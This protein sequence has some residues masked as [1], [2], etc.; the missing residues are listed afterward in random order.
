MFIIVFAY[1]FRVR[2]RRQQ[3]WWSAEYH[4][5]AVLQWVWNRCDE[6]IAYGW[7]RTSLGASTCLGWQQT[8]VKTIENVS[9]STWV[10]NLLGPYF[11]NMQHDYL[12]GS[13]I[14]IWII[15]GIAGINFTRSV[16][17]LMFTLD[18]I[19]QVLAS[20]LFAI[21]LK[22]FWKAYVRR[23]GAFCAGSKI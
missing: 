12:L 2:K 6:H 18:S 1:P 7:T 8:H 15:S 11:T 14:L 3:K 16:R 19:Q 17:Q 20:I 10:L 21:A 5:A 13:K 23:V 4:P 9:H 22:D